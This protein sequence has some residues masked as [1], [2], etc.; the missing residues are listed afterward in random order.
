MKKTFMYTGRSTDVVLI[1]RTSTCAKNDLK[2]ILNT[3]RIE[4]LAIIKTGS[5]ATERKRFFCY[6]VYV[7]VFLSKCCL[8]DTF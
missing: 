4:Y 8:K 3:C 1:C 7:S 5:S 6:V 2:M